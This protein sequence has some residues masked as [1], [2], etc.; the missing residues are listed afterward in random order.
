MGETIG[1]EVPAELKQRIDEYRE[2]DESRSAAIERLI[3]QSLDN[4]GSIRNKIQLATAITGLSWLVGFGLVGPQAGA[5]V[6]GAYIAGILI[7]SLLPWIR[8]S[9]EKFTA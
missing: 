4:D 9:I 1:A 6:G 7:W 2:P 5:A 8:G 3:R